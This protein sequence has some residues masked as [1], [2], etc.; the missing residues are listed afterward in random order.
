MKA[1]LII[2]ALAD[3]ALAAL[4]IGVSG[5]VI[6][7]GPESMKGG[8]LLTAAY[9]AAV[10]ACSAAPVAGFIL[11][12]YGKPRLALALTGMPLA[13]AVV[14]ALIPAPY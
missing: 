3:L 11:H 14:A 7:T 1:V 12:R 4:L 9:I 5:F 8:A 10:I 13:G 6:G 2:A